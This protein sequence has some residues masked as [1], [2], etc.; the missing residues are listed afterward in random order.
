MPGLLVN[1][2]KDIK[3]GPLGPSYQYARSVM[4]YKL[5]M[6]KAAASAGKFSNSRSGHF[7]YERYEI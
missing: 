4:A 6:D 5:A 3:L 2:R 1:T 7:C